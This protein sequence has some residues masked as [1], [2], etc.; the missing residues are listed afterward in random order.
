MSGV[1]AAALW[2]TSERRHVGEIA[3][4]ERR[5]RERE[6]SARREESNLW[7]ELDAG[8]MERLD[9]FTWGVNMS[10]DRF[11]GAKFAP[12]PGWAKSYGKQKAWE[13]RYQLPTFDPRSQG[14]LSEASYDGTEAIRKYMMDRS[15]WTE[16]ESITTGA[17]SGS[18]FWLSHLCNQARRRSAVGG[19][20]SGSTRPRRALR[21][22]RGTPPEGARARTWRSAAR[23]TLAKQLQL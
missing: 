12:G 6:R 7:G 18:A 5:E 1:R 8:R 17:D 21:V 10:F 13:F 2:G 16:D 9:H 3:K 20:L 22:G 23:D 4:A 15:L 11:V 19:V 14:F